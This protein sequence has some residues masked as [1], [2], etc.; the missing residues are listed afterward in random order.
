M[1]KKIQNT[2]LK[3][4]N[5]NNIL[6]E[7]KDN[8]EEI[9]YAS[10]IPFI[11]PI[12]AGM[13]IKVYD[14][15]TFTLASKLPYNDSPMYKFSVRLNNIDCPE[16]KSSNISE[17]ECAKLAKDELTKLILN[18]IVSLKNVSTEK[19]GRILADVYIDNLHINEHMVKKRLAVYYDGGTKIV[20]ENWMEY[21]IKETL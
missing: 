1:L 16:I 20:P 15:D 21:Y 9:D 10:A 19:Y 6:H 11:P 12:T 18:K 3:T 13:V 8:M 5:H 2:F 17:K 4:N 14:G 7:N